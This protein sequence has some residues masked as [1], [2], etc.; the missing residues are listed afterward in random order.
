MNKEILFES[1]IIQIKKRKEQFP[2]KESFDGPFFIYK[3]RNKIIF[4][5][6]EGYAFSIFKLL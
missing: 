5:K 3:R 2:N 1:S 6:G 4:K